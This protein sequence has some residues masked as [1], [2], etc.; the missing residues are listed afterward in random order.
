MEGNIAHRK[1]PLSVVDGDG[2]EA[3]RH[4]CLLDQLVQSPYLEHRL[5][6]HVLR[7]GHQQ[8]RSLDL[9]HLGDGAGIVCLEFAQG[10][11]ALSEYA[12]P[13]RDGAYE[14]ALGAGAKAR[15]LLALEELS[16]LVIGEGDLGDFEEVE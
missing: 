15:D 1:V 4:I 10:L 13:S 12:D 6:A 16:G 5:A 11:K 3:R 7:D 8:A 14:E 9:S 2:A